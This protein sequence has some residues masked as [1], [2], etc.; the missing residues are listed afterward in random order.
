MPSALVRDRSVWLLVRGTVLKAR[1]DGMIPS[2][3]VSFIDK[4][5]WQPWVTSVNIGGKLGVPGDDA[6][7]GRG[8]DRNVTKE[9]AH[10]YDA[11]HTRLNDP[12]V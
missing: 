4:L 3:Y 5:M 1:G 6:P 12:N 10:H 8:I 2:T 11:V 7:G 9:W